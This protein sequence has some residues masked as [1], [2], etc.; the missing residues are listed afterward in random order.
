[1]R[2]DADSD[3]YKNV[4]KDFY[5]KDVAVGFLISP[6]T[7]ELVIENCTIVNADV[8]ITDT[9]GSGVLID[10]G[11][12]ADISTRYV[13]RIKTTEALIPWPNETLIKEDMC[14]SGERQSDWCFFG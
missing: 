10:C 8:G 7:K 11:G 3:S 1:M 14:R 12:E 13:D 5:A 6:R 2:F 9:D 4:V